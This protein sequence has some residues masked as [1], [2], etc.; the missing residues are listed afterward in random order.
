MSH[1]SILRLWFS[2]LLLGA[3]ASGAEELNRVLGE[4]VTF[5]VKIT[6]P[7]KS[8]SWNKISGIRSGN[9]A[10]V[11]FGE[12]CALLVLLPAFENRVTASKDCRGLLLSHV[13]KEDAGQY[14]T[15]IVLQTGEAVNE[16]FELRVFRELLD[17]Q[18]KVTC[19]SDGAGNGTWQL[20]CSTKTWEDRVNISWTSVAKSTDP[21]PGSSVIQFVSQDLNATCTAENPV[22]NA[23]RMVSLKQICAERRPE[24]EAPQENENGPRAS[25]AWIVGVIVPFLILL[26]V[27]V[28]VWRKKATKRNQHFTT[29]PEI[30]NPP[31]S[32]STLIGDQPKQTKRKT[33][34]PARRTPKN[35]QEMPH[36]IYTAV[37]HPKQ[38]PLQT[39][40]EKIQK[41]RRSHQNQGDK[42]IY[43]E[44]TKP[45]ESE[46]SNIKTIY[47]TVQ[48]PR[49][50]NLAS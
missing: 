30:E 35:N 41:G 28:C 23:S 50:S 4:T 44:I 11:T 45:Q 33:N 2:I 29:H 22:S 3:E 18:L 48:N 15:Q 36:T 13:E 38:N 34:Q 17:S 31:R 8:I 5:Q 12:P 26:V 21:S 20:N 14:T 39:D 46:D 1:K 10:V 6:G 40:D 49:P 24:T 16:S 9:I 27:A 32:D 19:T 42:T 43:S 47:E 37:Q 25:S 7:Y